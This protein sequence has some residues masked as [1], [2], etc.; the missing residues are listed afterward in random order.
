[1]NVPLKNKIVA[2]VVSLTLMILI[3]SILVPPFSAGDT[4]GLGSGYGYGY[5]Y[6]ACTGT[7]GYWKNH[8]AAWPTDELTIGGVTYTKA[9][10]INWL[11][12]PVKDD[13]T[14]A[15]FY[16]LVAAMLNVDNGCASGCIEMTITAADSW[17]SMYGPVGNGVSASST[18]WESGEPLK[19]ELD[20]YNN[21]LLCAPH[22]D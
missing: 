21:G 6:G 19:D 9:E 3:I 15:M 14:I 22:C 5:G 16:Q 4:K 12:T 1:M 11:K 7:Q 8:G 17:M 18:A 10:A 20:D 2:F 13:M